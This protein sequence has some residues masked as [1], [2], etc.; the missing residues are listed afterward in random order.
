MRIVAK[1]CK[2][3]SI[4]EVSGSG[5]DSCGNF[6]HV[7]WWKEDLYDKDL[8]MF[9]RT[10]PAPA[11]DDPDPHAHNMKHAVLLLNQVRC[12]IYWRFVLGK[13]D[14]PGEPEGRGEQRRTKENQQ[15]GRWPG[16][17]I[18]WKK[19]TGKHKH[20]FRP[21]TKRRREEND[22]S[23]HDE[24]SAK[25]KKVSS[26]ASSSAA[27]QSSSESSSEDESSSSDDDSDNRPKPPAKGSSSSAGKLGILIFSSKKK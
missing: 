23:G 27:A 4:P 11:D 3:P 1:S 9:R 26:L 15:I 19:L 13:S 25:R 8:M 21:R 18:K 5:A 14:L 22:G 2:T 7:K 17:V 16:K 24:P 20:E 6:G 10:G 12:L